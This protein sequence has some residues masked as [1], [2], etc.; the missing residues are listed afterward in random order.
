MT[1]SAPEPTYPEYA[2]LRAEADR[3]RGSTVDPFDVHS[4]IPNLVRRRGHEWA[5]RV[6]GRTYFGVGSLYGSDMEL[7]KLADARGL[8]P[9]LPQWVHDARTREAEYRAEMEERRRAA[10][11]RDVE[12]WQAV[13][14]T[15][16]VDL[17]VHTNTTARVR[18]GESHHLAHAV[19]TTDVYSGI[20][21]VR[22]HRAGRAVCETETRAK[23]LSLSHRPEPTGTP[24]TCV[25]CMAWAPKL[26]ATPDP[27]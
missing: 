24:A 10:R 21:K 19:P 26:R 8:T 3:R 22:T 6:L 16:T 2:A 25:R 13:A 5:L 4:R 1:W 17:V 23:P 7:L 9:P 18:R 15:V 14:A 12:A 11:Q 20:R 27:K